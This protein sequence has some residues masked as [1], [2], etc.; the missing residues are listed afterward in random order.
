[1]PRFVLEVCFIGL[2]EGY[3]DYA[4]HT[5]YDGIYFVPRAHCGQWTDGDYK[6]HY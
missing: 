2:S 3:E 1:M 6:D 4:N 5:G